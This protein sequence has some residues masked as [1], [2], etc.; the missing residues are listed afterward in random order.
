MSGVAIISIMGRV[1]EDVKCREV[2]TKKGPTT[3]YDLSVA[4]NSWV[5]GKDVG[6]FY[7]ITLWPGRFEGMLKLLQK[8][9]SVF[10][11]GEF[12][13]SSYSN[14]NGTRSHKLVVELGQLKFTLRDSKAL[15]TRLAKEQIENDKS[16]VAQDEIL[17]GDVFDADELG[18][19]SQQ[20]LAES[21]TTIIPL[22]RHQEQSEDS[23]KK[24]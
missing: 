8:G 7:N 13:M 5:A 21:S 17:L 3:V 14:E 24:Q 23:N 18:G 6:T 11:S 10:L 20:E 9:K 15:V 22:K 19:P 1:T 4:V 12:Y 2:N 16:S